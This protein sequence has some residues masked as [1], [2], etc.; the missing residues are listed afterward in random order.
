MKIDRNQMKSYAGGVSGGIGVLAGAT[1][2]DYLTTVTAW[3]VSLVDASAPPEV[4]GALAGLLVIVGGFLVG[5][6]I[7]YWFP[8]NEVSAAQY[9]EMVREKAS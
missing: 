3:L 1:V 5:R 6:F 4:A 8:P 2:V 9:T 7:T